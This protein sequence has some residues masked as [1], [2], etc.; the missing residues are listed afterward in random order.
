MNLDRNG[1]AKISV[2]VARTTVADGHQVK[3]VASEIDYNTGLA[4]ITLSY[5]PHLPAD[6]IKIEY[7]LSNP[8]PDVISVLATLN[9]FP[10]VP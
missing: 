10:V 1:T 9:G 2:D 4:S 7:V 3:I 6:Y 8:E 5:Q